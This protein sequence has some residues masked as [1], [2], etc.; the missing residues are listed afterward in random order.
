MG[1]IDMHYFTIS[2]VSQLRF[3]HKTPRSDANA[4]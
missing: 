1:F 4:G 3:E 2:L